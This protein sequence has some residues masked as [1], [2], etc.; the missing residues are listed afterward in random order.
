VQQQ[1]WQFGPV[2]QLQ[3]HPVYE[4]F[5]QLQ[6]REL[7]LNQFQHQQ[8]FYGQVELHKGQRC[9]MMVQVLN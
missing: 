2:Q 6:F 8:Q 7:L 9:L 3:I 4:F 1:E 5:R